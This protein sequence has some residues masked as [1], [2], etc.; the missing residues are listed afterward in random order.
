MRSA[1]D[2]AGRK[3]AIELVGQ[4]F[5]R[6]TVR[7]RVG[8]RNKK[9]MWQCVCDCGGTTV[10]STGNLRSGMAQSCGCLARERASN[11]HWRHGGCDSREYQTWSSVKQRCLNSLYAGYA[12]YGGRGISVCERWLNSFEAF[13]ED[14]GPSPSGEHSIDR[15]DNDGNYE[16][17]NCRW[18]TKGEQMRNTRKNRLLTF[19]GK[20]QCLSAWAEE[21]GTTAQVLANRLNRSGWSVEEAISTPVATARKR[22]R[23]S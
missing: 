16:P 12:N 5:G 11:Y 17:G 21:M 15:I 8:T 9:A 22:L 2:I 23:K 13:C 3:C 6:L 4:T 7:E 1:S 19:C 10:T 14:M 18:A 20:T